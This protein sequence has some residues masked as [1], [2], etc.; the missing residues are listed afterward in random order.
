MAS[1]GQILY[2]SLY[3]HLLPYVAPVA[4]SSFAHGLFA[5]AAASNHVFNVSAPMNERDFCTF[6][7]IADLP[8]EALQETAPQKGVIRKAIDKVKNVATRVKDSLFH[9]QEPP[10]KIVVVAEV[11]LLD[12]QGDISGAVKIFRHIQKTFPQHEVSI[13]AEENEGIKKSMGLFG[14]DVQKNALYMKDRHL[15]FDPDLIVDFP[16]NIA[17]KLQ[18]PKAVCTEFPLPHFQRKDTPYLAI[19]EYGGGA[20]K[21]KCQNSEIQALGFSKKELG[22]MLNEELMQYASDPQNEDIGY[23]QKYVDALPQ[24]LKDAIQRPSEKQ[25]L[26]FGYS[27]QSASKEAFIKVIS[28]L[29][30]KTDPTL[31]LVGTPIQSIATIDHIF[32]NNLQNRVD[33]KAVPIFEHFVQ[34]GIHMVDLHWQSSSDAPV[35]HKT[36][37][38]VKNPS[39]RTTKLIFV[40]KVSHETMIDLFKASEKEVLV[41]GDQ[42]LTEAVSA[43]KFV[44]N[45]LRNHKQ[46]VSNALV[47][48]AKSVDKKLEPLAKTLLASFQD[49]NLQDDPLNKKVS[50]EQL[51]KMM[52]NI[53]KQDP[54]LKNDDARKSYPQEIV[55]EMGRTLKK[56]KESPALWTKFIQRIHKEHNFFPKLTDLVSRKITKQTDKK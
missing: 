56:L 15:P 52:S 36:I 32:K 1:K 50:K 4:L 38:L 7:D 37:S 28:S 20:S 31:V 19:R 34:N 25:P 8:D 9:V 55:Q 40:Q 35:Q 53:K 29:S 18:D 51:Q 26:Y 12:G 17:E 3:M 22:A 21:S 43:G 16:C 27:N 10:K 48:I 6:D 2:N 47:D 49:K 13:A 54:K 33:W 23:R 30:Q 39:G 46:G 24:H 41:T 45:D 42:S 11:H 14:K 44:L 5:V